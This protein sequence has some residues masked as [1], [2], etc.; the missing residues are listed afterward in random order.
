M[1]KGMKHTQDSQDKPFSAVLEKW[2]Q[3][4]RPKT[5]AHLS[6]LFAEKSFAIAFL[7]LMAIPASPLPTGGVSHVLEVVAMLLALELVIGRRT[8]WLPGDWTSIKLGKAMQKKIVPFLIRVIRWFEGYSKPRLGF[9]MRS[10][11]GRS[12]MGVLVFIFSLGA[13]LAPPF[14]GL[15]TLPSLGVVIIAL[16]FVLDDVVV[17]IVGIIVGILGVMTMI[18]LGS[19]FINVIHTLITSKIS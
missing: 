5:L 2:L 16:S 7:L 9:L 4:D 19:L 15:D 12:I 3:S 10:S 11:V 13:F 14:S 18:G 8:L 17:L 1:L 6:S